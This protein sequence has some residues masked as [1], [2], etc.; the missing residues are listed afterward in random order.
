MSLN[1]RQTR[2][3]PTSHAQLSILDW[4]WQSS[5]EFNSEEDNWSIL[6]EAQWQ[7]TE[8]SDG[9]SLQCFY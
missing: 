5:T 2:S 8:V 1:K 4:L 9:S 7:V 6:P 3:P